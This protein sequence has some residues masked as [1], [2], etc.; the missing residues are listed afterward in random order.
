MAEWEVALERQVATWAFL[1]SPKGHAFIDNYANDVRSK[2]PDQA[3][4]LGDLRGKA[5]AVVG[6]AEPI[7]VSKEMCALIEYAWEKFEPEPMREDDLFLPAGWAYL[8]KPLV[9]TDVWG[10]RMVH[11]AIAWHTGTDGGRSGVHVM[12][13]AGPDDEAGRDQYFDDLSAEDKARTRAFFGRALALGHATPIVFGDDPGDKDVPTFADDYGDR[14]TDDTVRQVSM[15]FHGYLQVLWRMMA[16]R[17][18]VGMRVQASRAS[19]RQNEREGW[20]ENYITVVTLRRPKNDGDASHGSVE[21]SQRWIVSGHW[22]WQPY[23]DGT[24][25]QI[26]IAPYVK[27]P[28]DKPLIVRGARIFKFAR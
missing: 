22:R 2:Y 28:D 25:R 20:R 27:G 8:E 6:A 11:R 18:A 1:R 24:H 26:W 12:T 15:D 16:Q 7:F 14:P 10:K 3:Y 4:L 5:E 23:G 13:F 21:W 9:T 17:V 19:R